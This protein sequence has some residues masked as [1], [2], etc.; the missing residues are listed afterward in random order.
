M[1]TTADPAIEGT[2][3]A[4][5]R[6]RC[7][8]A[9]AIADGDGNDVTPRSRKGQALF[10]YLAAHPGEAVTR[11]KLSAL[12]WSDRGEE[13][14]RASLRQCLY[15]LKPLL[16]GRV[17]SDAKRLTLQAGTA[18][19]DL[20]RTAAR[21][22]AGDGDALLQWLGTDGV[23]LD[24]LDGLDAC[25]DDWLRIERAR[26]ENMLRSLVLAS[27]ARGLEHGEVERVRELCT[28][29]ARR[30]P[31]DEQ[32]A[33]L[34]LRA[35]A[36]AGDQAALRRRFKQLE[37][38][39]RDEAD[40]TPAAETRALFER[41]LGETTAP[42]GRSVI[43]A[44][45]AA[46]LADVVVQSTKSSARPP[47]PQAEAT[48]A[49][50]RGLAAGFGRARWLAL[51][52]TVLI[53]AVAV[54][55]FMTRPTPTTEAV[56]I[57]VLPFENLARGDDFVA[58]GIW[59]DTRA[60][61]SRNPGLRVLGRTSSEAMANR[62]AD[63]NAYRSQLD[64]AYLLDGSVRRAGERVRVSVSLIRTEDGIELWSESFDG[65]LDDVFEMQAAIA[66]EIEGRVR[67]RLAPDRGVMPENIAT[68]G[69]VYAIYSEARAKL[70]S[71]SGFASVE[72]ATRL[73]KQAVALDPNFAPAWSQLAVATVFNDFGTSDKSAKL[74]EAQDYARRAVALAP[75][76]AQAHA[77]LAFAHELEGPVAEQALRRSLALDPNDAETWNWLGNSL[78]RQERKREAL[79]AYAKATE[80][81][82]LWWPAVLNK[83]SIITEQLEADIDAKDFAAAEREVA[84]IERAGDPVQAALARSLVARAR[85]DL[86][87]AVTPLLD[88]QRRTRESSLL[89]FGSTAWAALIQLGYYDQAEKFG[90]H[91]PFA[92][93]LWQGVI[94]EEWHRRLTRSPRR[95]WSRPYYPHIVGRLMI[96]QGRGAEFAG[97]YRA[98][99]FRSP[100]ELFSTFLDE[101]GYRQTA[102]LL[103][104]ALRET[105]DAG[106]AAA[107]LTEA[108]RRLAAIE[109][110]RPLQPDE[111]VALAH[112]RAVQG[113]DADALR[114][115]SRGIE[116]GW[117][118]DGLYYA[119]DIA[120]EP[121]FARLKDAPAFQA[122]RTRILR[123]FARERAELGEVEL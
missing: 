59:D 13:Q 107:I 16:E 100:A 119:R 94:L 33:A 118:P 112:M 29:F 15:E 121:A 27:A 104:L 45:K 102:P 37:A 78:N 88:I 36:L 40:A 86:S 46:P 31:A 81:D 114:L 74:R 105:G 73:L 50:V 111:L 99:G 52:L 68:T 54:A 11:E 35:D 92:K 10:A 26:R 83:M 103:A 89:M 9:F 122:P 63:V 72:A 80:I 71:R 62:N 5:L 6:L 76:L 91:P 98:A 120:Q 85:G 44:P 60:A 106:A 64:V 48:I 123:H 79:A 70:R 69:E 110:K 24:G 42:A 82:P 65:R 115:L 43:D 101:E 41:L 23:L 28:R 19:W 32:V 61:L 113:R 67:G 97:Y 25:F 3:Q 93:S 95:F 66:R 109:R 108:E 12:L 58:T 20:D 47:Q 38:G 34:G 51:A 55:Y 84:R 1:A 2:A 77:A 53:G 30:D 21:D 49:P 117:L 90:T 96:S 87:G 4:A 75:N 116:R 8:G 14:A 57:A 56:T 22:A 39:L 7:A 18:E 17:S